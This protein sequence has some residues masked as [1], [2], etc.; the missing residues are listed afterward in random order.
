MLTKNINF[1]NFEFK[2]NVKKIKTDL[3]FLL[4]EE[5]EVLRSLSLNYKNNYKKKLF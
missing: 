5:N 3:N 4:K 1:K 2:R